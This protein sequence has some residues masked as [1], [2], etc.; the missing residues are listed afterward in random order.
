M[1]RV[2]AGRIPTVLFLKR[3][4]VLRFAIG[5]IFIRRLPVV[6]K[7]QYKKAG[8]VKGMILLFGKYKGARLE[9][10]PEDYLMWLAKPTYSGR[11][12]K[13]LHSTELNWKV[14]FAIK[15]EARVILESRG[16]K[17]KGETWEAP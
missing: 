16:Y 1:I 17:L 5:T 12:Y 10:V 13:S 7:R 11:F 15:I 14:P 9:S 8:K 6:T 3:C 2:F 4:A